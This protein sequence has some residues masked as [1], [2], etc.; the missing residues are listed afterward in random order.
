MDGAIIFIDEVDG[1]ATTRDAGSIHE[2]TR[3]MLSVLLQHLE[4]FTGTSKSV[5]ICATNR[6]ED[7]DPALLS[8]FDLTINYSLPDLKT[9]KDVL[10]LYA[11]QLGSDE[12]ADLAV[13]SH[14]MSGR[15]IKESC[16]D[17]ERRCA[18]QAIRDH[19]AAVPSPPLLEDYRRAIYSRMV[20]SRAS[21]TFVD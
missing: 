2:A 8:R 10:R 7:L 17:A 1:L 5:L 13:L 21:G 11:M 6:A 12:L 20:G 18:A 16:Q 15:D 4:G 3:R 19:R 14:G 9:R